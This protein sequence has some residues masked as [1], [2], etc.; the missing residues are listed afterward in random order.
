[1][2]LRTRR[3]GPAWIAV[4]IE[5]TGIGISPEAR[6]KIFRIG[7]SDWKNGKKG[8][9]LGLYVVRRNIENHGGRIEITGA[10]GEGTTVTVGLPVQSDDVSPDATPAQTT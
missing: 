5:D 1:L 8:S 10:V 2:T 3:E 9:G 4:D 7:Y 6:E